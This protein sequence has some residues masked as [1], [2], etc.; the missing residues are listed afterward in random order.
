M[1]IREAIIALDF[2]GTVVTHAYPEVGEDIGAVPVLKE[3]VA[4]GDKLIL[5]T[6]RHDQLLED[7]VAWF[8]KHEIPLWA[9]NENPTQERWTTSPKIHADLVIDDSALGCP[10]CF[11]DGERRPAADWRRIRELLVRMGYLD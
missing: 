1:A 2:D 11:L 3:L 9:V 6:M 4:Q 10:T 7:A 5:W 8:R